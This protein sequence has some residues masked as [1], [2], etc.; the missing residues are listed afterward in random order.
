MFG[1]S[2]NCGESVSDQD[3][4]SDN[5][6][7]GPFLGGVLFGRAV[8]VKII[9]AKMDRCSSWGL[10]GTDAICRAMA[11]GT[12]RVVGGHWP[13]LGA[14]VAECDAAGASA[15]CVALDGADR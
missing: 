10:T 1:N 7:S 5:E 11:H 8:R 3:L 2:P 9:Q 14:T 12:A 6:D 15:T 13:R 4:G